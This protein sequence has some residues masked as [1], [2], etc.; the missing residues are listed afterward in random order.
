MDKLDMFFLAI[1][2]GKLNLISFFI[3]QYV[4]IKLES[5]ETKISNVFWLCQVVFSKYEFWNVYVQFKKILKIVQVETLKLLT[6]KLQNHLAC[7]CLD[8]FC[9]NWQNVDPW[10]MPHCVD[11]Q[12]MLLHPNLLWTDLFF[13]F[14][15]I[16]DSVLTPTA[17]SILNSK[18]FPENWVSKQSFF[19]WY[20]QWRKKYSF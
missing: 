2:K 16:I 10:I 4:C 17:Y 1:T 14:Q 6:C 20:W 19:F 8:I 9:T 7:K 11:P 12:L 13:I 15:G 18:T 5:F 3:L